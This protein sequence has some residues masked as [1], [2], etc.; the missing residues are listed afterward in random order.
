M[1][2]R[3]YQYGPQLDQGRIMIGS[4]NA[5]RRFDSSEKCE[6]RYFAY[7]DVNSQYLLKAEHFIYTQVV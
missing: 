6:L 3:S 2:S 1:K 5:L 4:R 7:F